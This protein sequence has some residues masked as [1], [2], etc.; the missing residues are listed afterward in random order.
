[1]GKMFRV[2]FTHRVVQTADG[3]RDQLPAPGS[4]GAMGMTAPAAPLPG[5]VALTLGKGCVYGFRR[6][7]MSPP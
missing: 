4:P 7:C 6:G 1:M 5:F 2:I 3:R